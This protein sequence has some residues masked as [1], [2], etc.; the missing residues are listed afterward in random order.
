MKFNPKN[1][2]PKAN[3]RQSTGRKLFGKIL[4]DRFGYGFDFSKEF[5]LQHLAAS[6]PFPFRF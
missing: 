5:P 2:I 3:L 4:P 1:E 6:W